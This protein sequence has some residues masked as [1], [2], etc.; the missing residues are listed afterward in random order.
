MRDRL[1]PEDAN[2]DLI[3]IC[4]MSG[5]FREGVDAFLSKRKPEWKGE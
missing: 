1:I 5:D 2:T 4:Y 3:K